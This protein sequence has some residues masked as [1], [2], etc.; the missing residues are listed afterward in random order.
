MSSVGQESVSRMLWEERIFLRR[1]LVST[2]D[3]EQTCAV[4]VLDKSC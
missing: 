4:I 3:F 2:E 1:V